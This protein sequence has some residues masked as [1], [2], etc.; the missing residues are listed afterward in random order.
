[1]KT[2]T[3]EAKEL[4]KTMNDDLGIEIE[5][6]NLYKIEQAISDW[7]MEK[8]VLGRIQIEVGHLKSLSSVRNL[9]LKVEDIFDK[10]INDIN[11]ALKILEGD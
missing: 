8:E 9:K 5:V 1:M 6:C 7:T 3:E 2:R 4:K 11:Q 10:E